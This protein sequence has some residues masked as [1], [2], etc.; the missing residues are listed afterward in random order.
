VATK[1][2]T[3]AKKKTAAKKKAAAKKTTAAGKS[4]STKGRSSEE[5]T[6][7]V[8]S[9]VRRQLRSQLLNRLR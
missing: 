6:D 4:R 5:K 1:K 8:F 7:L 2:K 9:D 3:S